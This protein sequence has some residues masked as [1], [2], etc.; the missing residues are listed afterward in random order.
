VQVV[1]IKPRWY[2]PNN[3]ARA[4][5]RQ[6]HERRH[7]LCSPGSPPLPFVR[8]A[9]GPGG[10]SGFSFVRGYVL[11]SDGP[12]QGYWRDT[13]LSMLDVISTVF[14]APAA[15]ETLNENGGG[16]LDNELGCFDYDDGMFQWLQLL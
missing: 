4:R 8:A 6:R 13:A 12:R 11:L 16:C 1:D 5:T 10:A 14:S 2:H 9:W 3:L 7:R 15:L